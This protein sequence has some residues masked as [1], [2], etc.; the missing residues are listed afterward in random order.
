MKFIRTTTD[1]TE[2]PELYIELASWIQQH[3]T[4]LGWRGEPTLYSDC[5]FEEDLPRWTLVARLHQKPKS[6]LYL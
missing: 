5:R 6:V 2:I 3:W 4:D 1:P